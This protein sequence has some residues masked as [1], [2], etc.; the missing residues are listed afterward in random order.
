M[1]VICPSTLWKYEAVPRSKEVA[2]H[3]VAFETQA[4]Y[5]LL[6]VTMY[7]AG[8]S[9]VYWSCLVTYFL[10][11]DSPVSSIADVARRCYLGTGEESGADGACRGAHQ[12]YTDWCH[13]ELHLCAQKIGGGI[14]GRPAFLEKAVG[15]HEPSSGCVFEKTDG[16][17]AH[18]GI[19]RSCALSI[20]QKTR[21]EVG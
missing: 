9:F 7:A 6:S 17:M 1:K 21:A 3:Q 10:L 2:N 15:I 20:A 14:A 8:S 16:C 12:L 5:P 18:A 4:S 13:H 19:C 11:K